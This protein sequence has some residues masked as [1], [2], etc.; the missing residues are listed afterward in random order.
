MRGS[1][2]SPCPGYQRCGQRRR[3]RRRTGR[4]GKSQR[5]SA[6][7][8]QRLGQKRI[9][10]QHDIIFER[11]IAFASVI[12]TL[13]LLRKLGMK[14]ENNNLLLGNFYPRFAHVILNK[15]GIRRGIKNP[16]GTSLLRG[17]TSVGIRR[18]KNIPA[19]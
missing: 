3:R 4:S 17:A 16:S 18:E 10:Q 12:C 9:F 7:D 1:P 8:L 14:Q 2:L 6:S 13:F 5:R 15:V 19:I 11:T